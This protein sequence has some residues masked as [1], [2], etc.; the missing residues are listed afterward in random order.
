MCAGGMNHTSLP[1]T[2]MPQPLSWTSWWH[3]THSITRFSS[4]VLPCCD[5]WTMW[6]LSHLEIA[7]E[8]LAQPLSR[9][10][11]T[12]RWGLLA[13]R[14]ARPN[15]NATP[16][17]SARSTLNSASTAMPRAVPMVRGASIPSHLAYPTPVATASRV[18]RITMVDLGRVVAC[19]QPT[20]WRAIATKTSAQI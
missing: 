7:L 4:S 2:S 13:A 19:S 6:W 15:F 14:R 10:I 18:A 8:H 1:T 5:H 11:A 16:S 3:A 20:A 17:S 9:S 12:S